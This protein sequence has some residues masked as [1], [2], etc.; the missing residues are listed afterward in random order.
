MWIYLAPYNEL[1]G[2]KLIGLL[3]A[4]NEVSDMFDK[5]YGKS[6]SEVAKKIAGR[7][8]EKNLI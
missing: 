8:I 6:S 7:N 1:I 4:S 5:K 3:I 2:G